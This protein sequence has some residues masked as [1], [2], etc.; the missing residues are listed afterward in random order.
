MVCGAADFYSVFLAYGQLIQPTGDWQSL[1]KEGVCVP[2]LLLGDLLL[3]RKIH[4]VRKKEINVK[5]KGLYFLDVCCCGYWRRKWQPTPIFLPRESQGQGSHVGSRLWGRTESDITKAT[6]QHYPYSLRKMYKIQKWEES[7]FE[8]YQ[9]FPKASADLIHYQWNSR[10]AFPEAWQKL[11]LEFIQTDQRP[12][13]AKKFLRAEETWERGT[14][15][16]IRTNYND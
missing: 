6:Q 15:S 1:Q 16:D 2:E 12:R 9:Q 14:L 7:T 11:I 3:L 10:R 4:Y 13:A 5:F 8:R